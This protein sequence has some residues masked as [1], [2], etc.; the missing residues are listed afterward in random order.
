MAF[1]NSASSAMPGF[2]IHQAS[3]GAALQFF[4]ALGTAELDAMIDAY[5]AGSASIKDKR[6]AVCMDFYEYAGQ[7]GENFKFYP[8]FALG[9]TTDS[10]AS[11]TIQDSG[12]GS[13]FNVSPVL[14]DMNAWSQSAAYATPSSTSSASFSAPSQS[15]TKSRSSAP[16]DRKTSTS[17]RSTAGDF[18]HLPGMKIM[19]KDGQDV[20]NSASRGCKTKEQ[21]DHAHLMRIIKA[22]DACKK[23]KTRC[24]TSHK[25]RSAAPAS[26]ESKPAKK[27]KKTASSSRAA[28]VA[29]EPVQP[30]PAVSPFQLDI[31]LDVPQSDA[32]QIPLDEE[33]WEQF[34]QY[35]EEAVHAPEYD[36]FFDPQGYLTPTSGSSQS[37]SSLPFTPA[38]AEAV[39]AESY[40]GSLFPEF[41]Q[42]QAYAD[43]P[44]LNPAGDHGTNYVDFNLYSPA[45]SFLEDDL[46]LTVS[47][48]RSEYG[49]STGHHGGGARLD[50]S[51]AS[52]VNG[53]SDLVPSPNIF[54]GGDLCG[55]LGSSLNDG[56]LNPFE[57]PGQ[58]VPGPQLPLDAHALQQLGGVHR[59]AGKRKKRQVEHGRASPGSSGLVTGSTSLQL[60]SLS[61]LT[62]RPETTALAVSTSSSTH[63]DRLLTCLKTSLAQHTPGR[64]ERDIA[65]QQTM[66]RGSLATIP[67]LESEP[68]T[69]FTSLSSL[70][71]SSSVQ[72]QTSGATPGQSMPSGTSSASAGTLQPRVPSRSTD[73]SPLPSGT[74][75]GPQR[76][77]ESV[78]TT[79]VMN[80]S[81][82]GR[83]GTQAGRASCPVPVG[84]SSRPN[85]TVTRTSSHNTQGEVFQD[86]RDCGC[87]PNSRSAG[88]GGPRSIAEHSAVH[89][90]Q[91]RHG[92][93]LVRAPSQLP[94]GSAQHQHGEFRSI[95]GPSIMFAGSAAAMPNIPG[96]ILIATLLRA[97]TTS[98]VSQS[99]AATSWLSVFAG[100]GILFLLSSII[101]QSP[102]GTALLDAITKVTT[103]AVA[104]APFAIQHMS[105]LT[106]DDDVKV[107]SKPFLGDT[108]DNVKSKIQS[109]AARLQNLR[110]VLTQA[111][112][113]R[114]QAVSLS[115]VTRL[116]G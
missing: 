26:P 69:S 27:T 14:S 113:R 112:S 54:Q 67:G 101:A 36:F 1:N 15:R 64:S 3:L 74:S 102:Y 90:K 63:Q 115:S 65:T 70:P 13:S 33:S 110:C 85:T 62:D 51:S 52:G 109:A 111:A 38:T 88:S 76:R 66:R 41:A 77:P 106:G 83:E 11:S 108:V 56:Q 29:A 91:G 23:K 22:C 10:P 47:A 78:P 60:S 8:V 98:A 80:V 18:S 49:Q 5:I 48:H 53:T 95:P 2:S 89:G 87:Y 31:S 107:E 94:A 103:I 4:P 92:F 93:G 82:E 46:Q 72:L 73:Y 55:G 28:S 104:L 19:T 9:S 99:S 81:G 116:T 42:T 84:M 37:P 25:K 97:V 39:S 75:S 96:L 40:G 43:L 21:R 34:I 7:T 6:R 59:L 30:A 12:Y 71:S 100:L 32:Y 79:S 17:S 20:T 24:D 58:S 57:D 68:Q 44:Y 50:G 45:S 105:P 16:A 86:A 61:S 114:V 35:E